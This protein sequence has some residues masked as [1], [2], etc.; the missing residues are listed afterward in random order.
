MNRL[1]CDH[2]GSEIQKGKPFYKYSEEAFCC[3]KCFNDHLWGG[4][5]E[6]YYTDMVSPVHINDH[7]YIDAYN[8]MYDYYCILQSH[9]K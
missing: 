8:D 6:V 1:I 2:C 9:N 3:K 4:R 5:D 7:V